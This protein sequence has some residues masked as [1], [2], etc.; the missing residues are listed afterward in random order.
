MTDTDQIGAF[1]YAIAMVVFAFLTV[2][3]L[4]VRRRSDWTGVAAFATAISA[5]WAGFWTAGYLELMQMPAPITFVEL[6]RVLVW[7]LAALALARAAGL[8]IIWLRPRSSYSALVLSVVIFPVAY[9]WLQSAEPFVTLVWVTGGYVLSVLIL[10]SA[11]QIFR[12]APSEQL[13][14]L[15]YLCV[16]VGGLFIF[17][18][19][20]YVAVIAGAEVNSDYLASRGLVNAILAVPLA[21]GIGRRSRA[22]PDG[23]APRQMVFYSFGVTILAAYVA[24]VTIGYHYVRQYGGSWSAVVAAI[25]VALTLLASGTIRA[26]VRVELMKTFFQYKYDYRKEWLRFIATLSES[27]LERVAATAVRAVAQ[28][29]NSPG[30]VVWIQERGSDAY[31]PAGAW[32]SPIPDVAPVKHT[33]SLIRF[34]EDRQWVID[35]EEMKNFPS[36][37][38]DLQVEGWLAESGDWWLIVPVFLGRRLYGFVV[39]EKPRA[40]PS[41]NFEDHDLLRTAGRHIAMHINQAE[42]DKHL[43]ESQQFGAYNRLTAFLMHDLNNL[44]AQQSLVVKNAER[45]R[46]NPKFVDDAI[47]TIAHSVT[48]MKRLMAQLSSSS[49]PTFKRQ[50]DVRDTLVQAVDRC[51]VLK[52][53][54]KL[55]IEDVPMIVQADS[56]RLITVFEHLIRNA[57]DATA[58]D[59][60]VVIDARLADG[61]VDISIK[62]TGKGMSSD[63]IRERLF[64]PFDSTKG[65]ES[66]GIG[67]YQ[68]RDYVRLLGGQIDVSSQIRV[69]TE[70]IVSIPLASSATATPLDAADSLE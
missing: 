43:A 69:G 17:D 7:L 1:G 20:M 41:L 54:P 59:G 49:K 31:V 26:R 67:A 8:S 44:I 2:L 22:V 60:E 48:R 50:T 15:S 55:D 21:F 45:F 46:R 42:S 53:V 40:V 13:P 6:I 24:V 33:A 3:S 19:F 65:S 11:E 16:A 34:L 25:A 68:A 18:L 57:Q 32:Q 36:R 9:L 62:D 23:R 66:M 28:I 14:S 38:E 12:N 61:S 30:G 10:L 64:R 27:G 4:S 58:P 63:F 39:L 56:E 52:P 51:Q 70:F 47:D 5:I 35:L 29:V 37:Y